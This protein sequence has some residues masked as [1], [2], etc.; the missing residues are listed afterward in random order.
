MN[1]S[2]QVGAL[3]VRL[4]IPITLG[5]CSRNCRKLSGRSP[6]SSFS[7]IE[8]VLALTITCFRNSPVRNENFGPT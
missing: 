5:R 3:K 8:W 7:P 2:K 4:E 1:E 6:S